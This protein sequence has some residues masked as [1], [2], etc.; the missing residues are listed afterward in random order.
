MHGLCKLCTSFSSSTLTA[1]LIQTKIMRGFDFRPY[2]NDFPITIKKSWK[3]V[4]LLQ[5]K[6]RIPPEV[7][8]QALF[9]RKECER[10][11]QIERREGIKIFTSDIIIKLIAKQNYRVERAILP[12]EF[13]EAKFTY[14]PIGDTYCLHP[15]IWDN[16]KYKLIFLLKILYEIK[17]SGNMKTYNDKQKYENFGLDNMYHYSWSRDYV[18]CFLFGDTSKPKFKQ[19]VE[20]NGYNPYKLSDIFSLPSQYIMQQMSLS[21]LLDNIHLIALS[22]NLDSK[23]FIGVFHSSTHM[24]FSVND[25]FD[26]LLAG[27]MKYVKKQYHW[28]LIYKE[29]SFFNKLDYLCVAKAYNY[30]ELPNGRFFNICSFGIE[31]SKL[32]LISFKEKLLC[33]KGLK[34]NENLFDKPKT[35]FIN[36]L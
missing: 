35:K 26:K 22:V 14:F 24:T 8:R 18:E 30:R 33:K 29:N 11:F 10:F 21:P 23:E 15:D 19:L 5:T 2:T 13:S 7:K 17:Y 6:T 32:N 36:F 27:Q 4:M 12:P 3:V 9:D 34:Y 20:K 16:E 1:L 25:I 28:R 31:K